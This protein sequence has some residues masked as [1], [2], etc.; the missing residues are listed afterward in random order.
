M[1]EPT[2]QEAPIDRVRDLKGAYERHVDQL[3]AATP[4]TQALE[5][6]VGGS[7]AVVG[8]IEVALLRF[9]GLSP[10][11]HLIDVGCGS[12]RLAKPLSSYLRGRYSGFDLVERLV[13]HAREIVCRNDWRFETI[14][15]IAIPESDGCADMV[16][17]FSVFTHLLHE[18]S[19]WYLQE[20]IRVLKPGGRIVFSFL[21]FRD[22]QHWPIFTATLDQSKARSDSPMNVFLSREA[23]EVWAKHL[24]ILIEHVRDGGD[25]SGL[26][27]APPLGQSVCVL[28]RPL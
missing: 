15:H 21:E 9:Y 23:I 5:D 13:Q 1:T 26:G 4:R 20:S 16:C 27:G 18:Q 24:N 10:D 11:D 14:D 22:P 6:A 8:P 3:M 17:F 19:Y 12:G 7:F 2:S 28:R 25:A